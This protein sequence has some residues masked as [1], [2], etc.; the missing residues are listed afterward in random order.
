MKKSF[1]A[2]PIRSQ[3]LILAAL[4]LFVMSLIISITYLQM[5]Y[6]VNNRSKEYTSQIILQMRKNV[7]YNSDVISRI[8]SNVSY[9]PISQEFLVGAPQDPLNKLE[10]R[11]MLWNTLINMKDMKQG[12]LDIVLVD[13]EGNY[14]DINS[15]W[16]LVK[17][18]LD[19]FSDRGEPHY[20]GIKD[21]MLKSGKNQCLVAGVNV[22]SVL[23]NGDSYN[24][25]GTVIGKASVIIEANALI[26]DMN[27]P[28]LHGT[29]IFLVDRDNK[30]YGGYNT[31]NEDELLKSISD[32]IKK[33]GGK[34]PVT[35]AVN[36][37]KQVIQ[38]EELPEIGGKI[39]SVTPERVLFADIVNI[40]RMDIVIL[41]AAVV[42]LS[43]PFFFIVNNIVNP[44]KNL[45]QFMSSRKLENLKEKVQLTGYAEIT[46]MAEKFNGM[47][48]EI[49][50]L[51]YK[52]LDTNSKLYETEIRQ[53]QAELG[54]L[55]SQINPHFLCNTLETVAGIAS[56][57]KNDSI[58][59]ITSSLGRIFRYSING[60]D[61]VPLRD[62]LEI[63]KSFLQIQEIRFSG[64]FDI[65]FD[66]PPE[67]QDLKIP[68]VILQPV[69][70]NAIYHG[71][72]M[73]MEK[74]HLWISARIDNKSD[75]YISVKDDGIGMDINT[76]KR[77]RK[78]LSSG[79]DRY[80]VEGDRHLNIGLINVDSRLKL[81]FGPMYG[82]TVNSALREGTEVVLKLPAKGGQNV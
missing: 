31:K 17:G 46:I 59:N 18:E 71:L 54:F 74:G 82:I 69:V 66:F 70:E 40:Q 39:I 11:N 1:K 50:N 19:N 65:T 80:C 76:L 34:G 2:L 55:R 61:E 64:R 33:G 67:V 75:L 43:I 30:A 63:V 58:V 13:M 25:V 77:I 23:R 22:Y 28:E 12:I 68:K 44:L 48:D 10:K 38:M 56:A 16:D 37:E 3:L 81:S 62:E 24:K 47:L 79:P 27:V 4:T 21:F 45:I 53:K 60:L 52:L 8:I 49:D 26:G 20:S 5:H 7:Q 32:Y 57:K 14:Y 29:R 41:I 15:G 72:E 78:E 51:T 42:L 35:L 73:K 36:G 9:N 6:F